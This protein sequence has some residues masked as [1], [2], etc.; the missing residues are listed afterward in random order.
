M[1]RFQIETEVR[2]A[3]TNQAFAH[4]VVPVVTENSADGAIKYAVAMLERLGMEVGL[5]RIAH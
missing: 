2:H 4:F 3:G 1:R 5:K